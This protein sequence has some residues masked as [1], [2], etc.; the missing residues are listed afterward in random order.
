LYEPKPQAES[1]HNTDVVREH[2]KRSCHNA[3]VVGK[4][5]VLLV[6]ED[7]GDQF[8][9]DISSLM[10]RGIDDAITIAVKPV[11]SNPAK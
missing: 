5:T 1:I 4:P 8:L 11:N 6:H 7:L 10:A 9:P 2:M 3:G